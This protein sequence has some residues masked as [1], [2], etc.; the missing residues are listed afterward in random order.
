M[1]REFKTLSHSNYICSLLLFEDKNNLISS[2]EDGTK[3]WN[4][5]NYDNI[6]YVLHILKKLG[7]DGMEDYV[8]LIKIE[9][10]LMMIK[11]F[12]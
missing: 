8:N 3:I 12:H 9:L 10:L 6:I 7:V 1:E 2:E 11:L 4:F 5:N